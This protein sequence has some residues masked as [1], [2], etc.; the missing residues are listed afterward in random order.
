MKKIGIGLLIFAALCLEIQLFIDWFLPYMDFE[1][2]GIIYF[3]GWACRVVIYLGI[4]VGYDY[5]WE[6]YT[7]RKS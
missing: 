3:V 6:K 1:G 4:V 2:I 7:I 5:L